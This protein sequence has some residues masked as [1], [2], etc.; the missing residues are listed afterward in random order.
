MKLNHKL[1]AVTA[2]LLLSAC[3]TSKDNKDFDPIINEPEVPEEP[4]V[5]IDSSSRIFLFGSDYSTGEIAQVDLDSTALKNSIVL[6]QDSRVYSDGENLWVL[7]A[8][9]A[10]NL[11]KL[12]IDYTSSED[13]IFQK[14]LAD[15]SNPVDIAFSSESRAWVSLENTNSIIQI[16]TEDGEQVSEYDLSQYAFDADNFAN[17]G[18]LLISGDTLFVAIQRRNGFSVGDLGVVLLLDANSGDSLGV[19]NFPMSNPTSMALVDDKLFV[20]LSGEFFTG[21]D[22]T[23]AL[24][25]VDLSDLTPSIIAY[26][27]DLGG[28]PTVI[29][30]LN[31]QLFVKIQSGYD[32]SFNAIESIVQMDPSTEV[33]TEVYSGSVEGGFAYSKTDEA[34]IIGSRAAGNEGLVVLKEGSESLIQFDDALAPY[35][36]QVVNY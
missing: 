33:V 20:S 25:S 3:I 21:A 34:W 22:S 10:D 16:N 31:N 7:E 5:E 15:N 11:V 8:L 9:G 2:S 19:I 4:V 14:S 13:I 1:V 24:V 26:D 29:Q 18:D 12:P 36:I 32:D 30:S 6:Y 35:S 27:T 23:R 28:S 17:P